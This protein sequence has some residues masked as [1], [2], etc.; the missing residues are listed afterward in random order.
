MLEAIFNKQ[1]ELQARLGFN[2]DTMSD[3]QRV[4]YLKEYSLHAEQELHE[5]LRELP[6]FKHWSKK[7]MEMNVIERKTA[8]RK[9][10]LEYADFFHFVINLALA[11]GLTAQDLFAIY[12][13]KNDINR[14]RQ[15]TGY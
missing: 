9:A 1:M 12:A 14:A 4:A 3:E 13:E 7:S 11:L 5:M 6:Y 8:F 2:L 10:Q 15:E